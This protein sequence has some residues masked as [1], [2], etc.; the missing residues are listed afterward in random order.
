MPAS[1]SLLANLQF[2]QKMVYCIKRTVAV[3]QSE[4]LLEQQQE[5]Q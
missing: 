4:T 1:I 3:Q 5:Q 2:W